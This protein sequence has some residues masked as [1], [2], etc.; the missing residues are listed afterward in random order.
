MAAGSLCLFSKEKFPYQDVFLH[1]SNE[2][3]TPVYALCA[4]VYWQARIEL[5]LIILADA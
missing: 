3:N 5:E 4:F 1:K 2:N